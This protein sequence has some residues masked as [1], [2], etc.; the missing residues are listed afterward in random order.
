MHIQACNLGNQLTQGWQSRQ[1][2]L[3][4]RGGS[5]DAKKWMWSV[6]LMAFLI[7]AKAVA[8]GNDHSMALRKDGSVWAAG[9]NTSGQLC[10]GSTAAKSEFVE[11]IS[12]GV[13]AVAAGSDYSMVLKLGGSV[14][15]TDR[16]HRGQ[17]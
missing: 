13:Q 9:Q 10:D 8:V 1:P 11:V 17:H 3:V 14:W 6:G 2:V 15:A 12:K 16:N 7:D 4:G 5:D